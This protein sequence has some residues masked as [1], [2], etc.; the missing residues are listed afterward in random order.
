MEICAAMVH[1]E[2]AALDALPAEGRHAASE[3]LAPRSST[4][5]TNG[6]IS[7]IHSASQLA[8]SMTKSL[9]DI[10]PLEAVLYD[11]SS[12]EIKAFG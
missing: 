11:T 12:G 9:L 5:L 4:A 1:T 2:R 10:T 8:K 3:W 6:L 7:E